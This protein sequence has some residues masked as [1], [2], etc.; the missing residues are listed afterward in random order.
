MCYGLLRT[1]C[2]RIR[3]LWGQDCFRLGY[4]IVIPSASW[5]EGLA[6]VPILND[7][8]LKPIVF[9]KRSLRG[10]VVVPAD[11]SFSN[12]AN[13]RWLCLIAFRIFQVYGLYTLMSVCACEVPA[14]QTF[15]NCKN[16][17]GNVFG[18]KAGLN[19]HCGGRRFI[20]VIFTHGCISIFWDLMWA[21]LV[22]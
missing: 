14:S 22:G 11:A 13:G 20:A 15:D 2:P 17:F 6:T 1:L 9:R 12:Q 8:A 5:S 4:D 7:F 10:V 3:C 21:I 18:L 19:Q 16:Q